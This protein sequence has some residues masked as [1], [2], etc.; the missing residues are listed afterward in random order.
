M[1]GHGYVCVGHVPWH[2]VLAFGGAKER[3]IH[4]V[5]IILVIFVHIRCL[6]V[7]FIVSYHVDLLLIERTLIF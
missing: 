3:L 4:L 1:H 6:E 2:V 5:E 7:G